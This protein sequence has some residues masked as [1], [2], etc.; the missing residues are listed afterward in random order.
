VGSNL[1]FSSDG[2]RLFALSAD[3]DLQSVEV[4]R[5]AG[6]PAPPFRTERRAAE[7]RVIAAGWL[8]GRLATI[9]VVGGDLE[10][11]HGDY[12]LAGGPS[13][14]CRAPLAGSGLEVTPGR[15][16]DPYVRWYEQVVPE[17]SLVGA[18]T[19]IRDDH[20]RLYA[21]QGWSDGERI[22]QHLGDQV[23]AL[24][25]FEEDRHA[26]FVGRLAPSRHHYSGWL[27]RRRAEKRA[28][29]Q[30]RPMYIAYLNRRA[31]SAQPGPKLAGD[32][33]F[34]AFGVESPEL[35]GPYGRSPDDFGLWAVEQRAGIWTL[36]WLHGTA[37]VA[38]APGDAVVGVVARGPGGA[39]GLVLR[40]EDGCELAL[41]NAQGRRASLRAE[42]PIDAIAV[43]PVEPLV[44]YTAGGALWFARLD[45]I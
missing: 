39:P 2:R 19:L 32:G 4:P 16:L 24:A 9:A 34:R 42:A 23:T 6:G 14:P 21:L 11:S 1:V 44:A 13:T 10:A 26:A 25:G 22:L 5:G 28:A 40:A 3:G 8:D 29:A 7:G 38:V 37:D 36:V 18:I 17:E 27:E 12:G 35:P 45:A 41:L 31:I 33:S 30:E 43:S 20:D 15:R